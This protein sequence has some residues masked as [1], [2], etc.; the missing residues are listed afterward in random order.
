V[1]ELLLGQAL[2]LARHVFSVAG[3]HLTECCKNIYG[4]SVALTCFMS[5][6]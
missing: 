1:H 4:W 3:R 6:S 5:S 2:H